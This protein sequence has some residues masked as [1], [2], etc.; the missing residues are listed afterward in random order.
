M[1]PAPLLP[2]TTCHMD[3]RVGIPD[4]DIQHLQA[5]HR[6]PPRTHLQCIPPPP[7][8]RFPRPPRVR[9]TIS[10]STDTPD[11]LGTQ[12]SSGWHVEVVGR[13]GWG[14]GEPGPA[15]GV[16]A[17]G[18][19]AVPSVVAASPLP[20]RRLGRPAAPRL[21]HSKEEGQGMRKRRMRR[22]EL[23]RRGE[24]GISGRVG[25]DRLKASI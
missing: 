23:V 12:E 9:P 14:A 4:E 6:S 7:N 21:R 18:P 15:F 25:T 24:S 16:A 3:K 11:T 17:P 19:S 22:D 2:S 1:V 5:L 20:K 13:V 8:L 10:P